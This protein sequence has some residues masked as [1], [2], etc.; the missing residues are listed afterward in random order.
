MS[1]VY[2]SFNFVEITSNMYSEM[3]GKA[4]DHA[5]LRNLYFLTLD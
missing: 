3:R 2:E 4:R 1:E 5:R